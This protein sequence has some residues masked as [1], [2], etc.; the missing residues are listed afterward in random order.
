MSRLTPNNF[1][2]TLKLNASNPEM[3]DAQF[4]KFVVRTTKDMSEQPSLS[5]APY[6]FGCD[7]VV[8]DRD[9]LTFLEY[10]LSLSSVALEAAEKIKQA[11][12]DFRADR[13]PKT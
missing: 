10:R 12:K 4:R 1:F 6:G 13:F 3:T 7:A 9:V 2:S 11:G 5:L 8:A